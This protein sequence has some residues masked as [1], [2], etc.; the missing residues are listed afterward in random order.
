MNK[1]KPDYLIGQ[2][3]DIKITEF[4]CKTHKALY[5]P[6]LAWQAYA[7]ERTKKGDKQTRCKVCGRWYFKDEI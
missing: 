7:E 3:P 5:Y 4:A 2:T 6:Y 1:N